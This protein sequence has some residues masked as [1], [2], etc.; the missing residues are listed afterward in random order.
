[1]QDAP[2]KQYFFSRAS[3]AYHQTEN[4]IFGLCGFYFDRSHPKRRWS[5]WQVV[6]NRPL[7]PHALCP[8]CRR[9]ITGEPEP[10]VDLDAITVDRTMTL[11]PP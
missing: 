3:V 7:Q 10:K 9:T 4:E 2:A 5:D 6:S 8:K 11:P 1:M